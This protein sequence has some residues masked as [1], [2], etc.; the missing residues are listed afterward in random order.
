M[1]ANIHRF[2]SRRD[3]RQKVNP[4]CLQHLPPIPDA[5]TTSAA[6]TTSWSLLFWRRR[7]SLSSTSECLK[8][9][10]GLGR[11]RGSC[12][13]SAS[14]LDHPF[15]L[16]GA[17]STRR[18]WPLKRAASTRLARHSAIASTANCDSSLTLQT[19][20]DVASV[21]TAAMAAAA[22]P[23]V[24]TFAGFFMPDEETKKKKFD[25]DEEKAV[26]RV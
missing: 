16:D 21:A 24:G 20:T 8:D 1:T 14:L 23:D 12:A 15:A 7:G 3:R 13:S 5:S 18:P 22:A 6:S 26:R 17:G 19:T 2:L 25:K 9:D 4:S 11:G 10:G